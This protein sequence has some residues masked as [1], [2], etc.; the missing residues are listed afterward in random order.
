MVAAAG[1]DVAWSHARRAAPVAAVVLAAVVLGVLVLALPPFVRLHERDGEATLAHVVHETPV[2]VVTGAE[3]E[4]HYL[5]RRVPAYPA[6]Q[7]LNRVADEHDRVVEAI[8][9][10][11]D[12]YSKPELVPDYSRCLA[13]AGLFDGGARAAHAALLRAGVDYVLVDRTIPD[14]WSFGWLGRGFRRRALE[15]VYADERISLYRVRG[16]ATSHAV[17]P[18][19]ARASLRQPSPPRAGDRAGSAAPPVRGGPPPAARRIAAA[20]ALRACGPRAQ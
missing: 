6:I 4:A 14:Q 19:A 5:G 3:R 10:F 18:A 7:H 17:P 9:P 13:R 11:A 16:A 1:F 8:D 20:T 2:D 15:R 12:F